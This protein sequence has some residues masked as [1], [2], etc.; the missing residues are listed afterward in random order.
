[1]RALRLCLCPIAYVWAQA[2]VGFDASAADRLRISTA[3]YDLVLSKANGAICRHAAHLR[4]LP[5]PL[6][7]AAIS[8]ASPTLSPTGGMRPESGASPHKGR[9]NE[10]FSAT[11]CLWGRRCRRLRR[12]SDTRL[13]TR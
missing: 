13:T 9:Q 10:S 4:E 5:A 7:E 8:P 6:K 11:A 2:P 1:M 12:T 3:A